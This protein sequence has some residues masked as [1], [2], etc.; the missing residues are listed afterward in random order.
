VTRYRRVGI[1][2][3]ALLGVAV[4]AFVAA[5]SSG[6]GSSVVA[7]GSA[8]V[9]APVQTDIGF[10][11]QRRL[12]EHFDKHGREFGGIDKD[13]YLRRAQELRDRVAGGPV[14]ETVRGDGVVTRFDRD[15]GDFIAFNPDRTIR[16]FFRPNDGEAYFR[17]QARR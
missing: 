7:G 8:S 12:D 4:L 9:A 10:R 13:A 1:W 16:T 17:R 2:L 14:L 15:S 6:D 11:D 3:V 5:R